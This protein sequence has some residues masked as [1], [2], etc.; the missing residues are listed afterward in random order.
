M[1]A[2]HEIR[3]SVA[4]SLYEGGPQAHA[5]AWYADEESAQAIAEMG[6]VVLVAWAAS[7]FAIRPSNVLS[8]SFSDRSL[9]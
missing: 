4:V 7:T 5:Y 9:S 3:I 8:V 1:G 2:E 6:P